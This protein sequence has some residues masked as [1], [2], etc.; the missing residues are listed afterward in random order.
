MPTLRSGK[1]WPTALPTASRSSHAPIW[2]RRAEGSSPVRRPRRTTRATLFQ[3]RRPG[4]DYGESEEEA[5]YWDEHY[6]EKAVYG[7]EGAGG[8][9]HVPRC[10]S[11]TGSTAVLVRCLRRNFIEN[12]MC[13]ARL[14][15][16]LPEHRALD[17]ARPSAS[18]SC[19]SRGSPSASS[20]IPSACASPPAAGTG[21]V[22]RG[23]AQRDRATSD[24]FGLAGAAEIDQDARA[25]HAEVADL[26]GVAAEVLGGAID[27]IVDHRE[28]FGCRGRVRRA[29]ARAG[30]AGAVARCR[31]ARRSRSPPRSPR[32]GRDRHVRGAPSSR[33]S[34]ATFARQI[35]TSVWFALVVARIPSHA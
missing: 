18:S 4:S 27:R 28:R 8:G 17:H 11:T 22:L 24:R 21:V 32:R 10:C 23:L 7:A 9:F 3:R 12:S 16:V 1:S 2:S 5:A 35:R 31:P 34:R 13:R 29:H 33:S 14:G 25:P 15:V 20:A 30:R 19:A 26:G 6:I